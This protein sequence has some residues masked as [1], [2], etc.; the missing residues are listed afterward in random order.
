[1]TLR[2]V[3]VFSALLL[4]AA[5]AQAGSQLFE[6]SWI[7]KAFGNELTGGTGDF[8]FYSAVGIP[9]GIQ[10]N[11]KQPRCPFESTPTDGFGNFAPLGLGH[12]S[13]T[14]PYCRRWT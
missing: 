9:Q 3:V 2:P 1:M 7:V 14:T 4:S 8:E 13:I 6:G 12:S 5:A 10:C 11:A